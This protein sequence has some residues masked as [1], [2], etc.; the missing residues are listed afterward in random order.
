VCCFFGAS[1]TTTLQINDHIL[2]TH[3]LSLTKRK[4]IHDEH[5]TIITEEE[6]LYTMAEE[7]DLVDYE[8]DDETTDK[9]TDG[10]EIKKC[11]N[12]PDV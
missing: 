2:N 3:L 9:K 7:E 12:I 1:Y 4:T 5:H 10:K 8:E 6:E 11:V